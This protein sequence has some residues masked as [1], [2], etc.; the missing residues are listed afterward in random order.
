M[1]GESTM[2]GLASL[3]W[4]GVTEGAVLPEVQFHVSYAKVLGLALASWDFFPGHHDPEYAR[5]QGQKEIYL[6]TMALAGFLDRIVLEWA[7]SHWWLQKRTMQIVKSVY[8]GDTLVGE[9][10]VVGKSDCGASPSIAVELTASNQ[11]G[12]LCLRGR[13]TIVRLDLTQ[14]G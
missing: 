3:D 14:K 13:A 7:G 6:N 2:L 10:T 4:E 1:T 8:A 5:S 12:E 9:G 11:A